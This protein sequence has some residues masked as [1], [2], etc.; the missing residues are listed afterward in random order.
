MTERNFAIDFLKTVAI[1]AV[2]LIH[3]TTPFLD[4]FV[5]FSFSFDLL[6]LLNQF[7]RFAVPLFFLSSGFLLALKYTNTFSII[8]FFSFEKKANNSQPLESNIGE[9]YKKRVLRILPPYLFWVLIY[10]LFVFPHSFQSLF[11]WTFVNSF[12]TGNA[13][14]QLYFIPGI[15]VLYLLFPFFIKYKSFFLSKSFL[16]SFF[17]FACIILSFIYYANYK[18]P[19][20]P[21]FRA[22][23]YNAF[24]FLIGILSALYFEKTKQIM[25]RYFT[26]FVS[27]GI[28]LGSIIFSESFYLFKEFQFKRFL[29]EQWRPSVMM[30][31]IV[32]AVVFTGIYETYLKTY[33]KQILFLSKFSFGVFFI[34]V[35][36]LDLIIPVVN[37]LNLFNLPGFFLSLIAVFTLSYGIIYIVSKIPK[38]GSIIS[39]T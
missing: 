14:Y 28:I 31:G 1:F 7:S 5:P 25:R 38:I 17:L 15:F 21:P 33:S 36:I 10:Y 6:L 39:A 13:S 23:F 26:F 24:P 29:I 4:K 20:Y 32:S 9:F 18:L 37:F 11:S 22:A 27:A 19:L 34:H 3:V 12:L 30:Y 16:I 35:A 8:P 2:I